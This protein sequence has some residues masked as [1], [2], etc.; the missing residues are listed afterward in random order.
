MPGVLYVW[1]TIL[2]PQNASFDSRWYHQPIAEI[3]VAQGGIE[4]F[5]EG[6]V[7]GAFPQL[8]SLLYAW[9]FSLPGSSSP[10][11]TSSFACSS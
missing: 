2:T 10:R 5:S 4:P 3:Y 6:W 1:F 9:A 8:A 11:R 7:P